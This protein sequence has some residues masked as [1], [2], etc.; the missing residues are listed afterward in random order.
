MIAAARSLVAWGLPLG[1][2]VAGRSGNLGGLGAGS[3]GLES[4][5][6]GLGFRVCSLTSSRLFMSLQYSSMY[7]SLFI[8]TSG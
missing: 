5:L 7:L 1:L 4:E 2:L 3:C 6:E 8:K